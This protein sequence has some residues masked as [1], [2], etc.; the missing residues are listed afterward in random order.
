MTSAGALPRRTVIQKLQDAWAKNLS[1][2]AVMICLLVGLVAAIVQIVRLPLISGFLEHEETTLSDRFFSWRNDIRRLTGREPGAVD[3]PVIVAIDDESARRMGVTD[4]RRWPE[5]HYARLVE[6]LREAGAAVIA[7]DTILNE[8]IASSSS[9]TAPAQSSSLA[10]ELKKTSNLV[11]STNV[12]VVELISAKSPQL[13]Y[14]FHLPADQYLYAVGADSGALGNAFIQTDEDGIVRQAKVIQERFRRQ[15]PAFHKTFALRIL[16]KKM[17]SRAFIDI[18]ADRI[19]IRDRIF[20]P[21]FH[22]NFEGG[23]GSFS[24][25]PFWRAVEWQKHFNAGGEPENPFKDRIVIIGMAESGYSSFS[26]PSGFLTPVSSTDNRMSSMEIQANTVNTLLK[27]RALVPAESWKISVLLVVL[28][29]ILG[30]V[31]GTLQ[32]RPWTGFSFVAAFSIFWLVGALL[33]FSYMNISIPVVVP[34]LSVVLPCWAIVMTDQNLFVLGERRRHTRLFRSLTAKQVAQQIDRTQLAELG[35]DG[36]RM[37]ITVSVCEM[38]DLIKQLNDLPPD[39]VFQVF[40]EC[41]GIMVNCVCEHKGLV[42]RIWNYGISAFWGAPLV[43]PLEDQARLSTQCALAMKQRLEEWFTSQPD[44]DRAIVLF[45]AG[46]DTGEGLCGTI[47]AGARDTTIS[48]YGAL[49]A[50]VDA[51]GELSS[52]NSM[53]G[54]SIILSGSTAELLGERMELREIDRVNLAT[55]KKHQ[56]IFELLSHSGS[57]PAAYEEAMAIFKQA[58]AAFEGG[59]VKEAEQLFATILNMV[60]ADQPTAIML[61]RCKD[62]LSGGE[63][64]SLSPSPH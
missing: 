60:P 54:T 12:D 40:N 27:N 50:S 3:D 13:Y 46:I 63:E 8:E 19:C 16:E 2:R 43:M 53:Y 58:R 24:T 30:K 33:A 42:D 17:S 7:F 39:R 35:L 15:S 37:T 25:I 29:I 11:L 4:R 31:L 47:N 26:G 61:K 56:P 41:L 21:A 49:G 22:I 57:M 6:Q 44:L 38:R 23:P 32:G 18:G 48:Q 36:R 14:Q 64:A 28:A 9:R 1:A 5:R 51:A 10:D 34:I 52:L 55:L 62:L 45:N 20:P 59:D